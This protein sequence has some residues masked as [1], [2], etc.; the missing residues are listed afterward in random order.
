MR[1]KTATFKYAK[2]IVFIVIKYFTVLGYMYTLN[3][4]KLRKIRNPTQHYFFLMYF[5]CYSMSRKILI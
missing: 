2:V 4:L 5:K 1:R 3:Y